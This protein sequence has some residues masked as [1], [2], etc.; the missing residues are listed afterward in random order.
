MSHGLAPRLLFLALVGATITVACGSSTTV[1]DD[2]SGASG[3]GTSSGGG[4]TSTA[5]G[6]AGGTS[7]STGGMGGAASGMGGAG[8]GMLVDCTVDCSK[9]TAP[10]CMMA[11][12]NMQTGI[13]DIVAAPDGSPCNN[14]TCL[15]GSCQ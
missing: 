12:C 8:G 14:G 15:G 13:C 4:T 6:G 10:S 9:I 1:E 5:M 3:A 2:G 7:G 11:V